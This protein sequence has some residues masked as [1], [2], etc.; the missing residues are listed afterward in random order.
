MLR[1]QSRVRSTDAFGGAALP[2]PEAHGVNGPHPTRPGLGHEP[3]RDSSG[4]A[5]SGTTEREAV[6]HRAS[7]S[8]SPDARS[9]PGARHLVCAQLADWGLD[10]QSDVTELLISELLTNALR[11][12]WGGPTVTLSVQDGTLH[13]EIEDA[14]PALLPA[15]PAHSRGEDEETGRGLQLVDLLSGSW[16]SDRSP[17]GKIVW[18]ELPAQPTGGCHE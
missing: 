10:E 17:T 2:D 6:V 7:W 12:A 14:N 11:H 16:G 15:R 18:F 1:E 9:V 4:T 13:C 5:R 8:F 3:A